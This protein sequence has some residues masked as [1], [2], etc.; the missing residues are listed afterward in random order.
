M[1]YIRLIDAQERVAGEFVG[2]SRGQAGQ[3]SLALA[4]HRLQ[5]LLEHPVRR[6]D[7]LRERAIGQ[8]VFVSATYL[9]VRGKCGEALQRGEH[10]CR[11]SL[12]QATAADAEQR[13]AAEQQILAVI[14][15]MAQR[16]TRNRQHLERALRRAQFN[17]IPIL[18][19]MG[20]QL[21]SWIV[22]RMDTGGCHRMQARRAADMVGMMVGQEDGTQLQ[23]LALQG[24]ENR[25]GLAGIDNQGIAKIIV[26]H[27][28]VIVGQRR[29][30]LQVQMRRLGHG[31]NYNGLG[32]PIPQ[33]ARMSGLDFAL[34]CRPCGAEISVHEPIGDV[35]NLAEIENLLA[36][37][38]SWVS[39]APLTAPAGLA[40]S[41]APARWP[42]EPMLSSQQSITR[43]HLAGDG[44]GGDLNCSISALPLETD[45]VQ[46]IVVRHVFDVLGPHEELE[47]ELMRVLAPAGVLYLFAF[48]PA[49]T[50]RLWW[51]R[52][53]LHGMPMPR[54]NSLAQARRRLAAID[55]VQ[56]QQGYLGGSWPSP[57]A[58]DARGDGQRWHGAWSLVVRKQRIAARPVDPHLQRKRVVLAPGLAR[59][60]SRRAGM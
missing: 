22:W 60:S 12:E 54:W 56:S 32:V 46:M 35:F 59:L 16:M 2:H 47:S 29:Q 6:F 43:L 39:S 8:R 19:A 57:S 45:S 41:L 34:A 52:H 37:E 58:M 23:L 25:R 11:R 9:C 18:D 31:R 28:D 1:D 51:L 10:L 36:L 5:T 7:R 53:A 40:I 44:L 27:P 17:A 33:P 50:W 49:S 42:A 20:R 3:A 24:I 13:I 14:G 21:D 30:W 48:N 4:T 15:D 26:E 38:W 55:A